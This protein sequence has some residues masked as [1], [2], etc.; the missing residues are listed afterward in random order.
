MFDRVIEKYHE[1]NIYKV[2][3]LVVYISFFLF[4]V[5]LF[6]IK[7]AYLLIIIYLLILNLAK[8]FDKVFIKLVNYLLPIF[9]LGY[10]LITYTNIFI[11]KEEVYFIFLLIIKVLLILDYIAILLEYNKKKKIK[12]FKLFK[13]NRKKY[14]FI[15]LR[16]K[17][18]DKFKNIVKDKFDSYI[19][20]HK[21][22]LNS[23]YYKVIN[24][25]YETKYRDELEEYV[26]INYL[27]FYKNQSNKKEKLNFYN[28][29]FLGIHVII[30]VLALIVR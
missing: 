1:F 12:S 9:L 10:L 28:F 4:L 17:N 14:S 30:F 6:Y 26:W 13:K 25:N 23:D 20:E 29:V 21:I 8:Y 2:N 5:S 3:N 7:N 15:E 16:K 11:I 19:K 22:D 18:I 24:D 27:R